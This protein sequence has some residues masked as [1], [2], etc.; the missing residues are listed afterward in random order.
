MTTKRHAVPEN[1]AQ[2]HPCKNLILNNKTDKE[3]PI[4]LQLDQIIPQ[5]FEMTDNISIIIPDAKKTSRK[6]IEDMLR[7]Y[8]K[9]DDMQI[10]N[11][12]FEEVGN[13]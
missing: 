12:D 2:W 11:A 3:D 9:K 8:G 1:G 13:G 7:K 6:K 10:E 5:N 4:D